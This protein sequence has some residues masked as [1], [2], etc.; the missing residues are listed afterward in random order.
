M[1]KLKIITMQDVQAEPAEFLWEPYIP[2]GKISIVQG[3]PGDSKTTLLLAIAAAVTSGSPLPGGNSA[4]PASV[5]YQTA[6]DGLAD[7]I[8]PRLEQLG[9]D[10]SRV[11]VVDE[12]EKALSLPF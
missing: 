1:A 10:C 2:L 4:S 7:T 8:K 3:D 6:E 11:H 9:A 5:I 12:E